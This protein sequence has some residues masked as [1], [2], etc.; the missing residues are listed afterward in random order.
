MALVRVNVPFSGGKNTVVYLPTQNGTLTYNGTNQTP[1]WLNYNPS[2]ISMTGETSATNAGTH[3]VQCTPKG[4]CFW[5]DETQDTKESTWTM[6]KAAGVLSLSVNSTEVK[7]GATGN[8]ILTTA[9]DGAI[10][11]T[12]N[13]T[14]VATVNRNGNTIIITGVK[15]GTATIT[16]SQA[17]GTNHLAPQNVTCSVTVSK[18]IVTVPTVINTS[19]TYNS[20]SQSPTVSNEPSSAI[21]NCTGKSA[22]D[23]GNYTL[24]YS[25]TDTNKYVWSDG[26]TTDKSTAWSIAKANGSISLSVTSGTVTYGTPTTFT[27]TGNTSGGNLSVSSADTRYATASLNGNTVTVTCV[28]CRAETTIITVTSAAT[29]NYNAATATYTMTAAK[30]EGRIT[31]S[32]TS[33]DVTC[34]TPATF[35]VI[36]N[37]SGGI[38]SVETVYNPN[39]KTIYVTPSLNGNTVTVNYVK[40]LDYP[41][42]KIIQV[43]SAETE[44]Y[45]ATYAHYQFYTKKANG[46]VI[47]SATSGTVAY[48]TPSNFE[49][50]ENKSGGK[51][52]AKVANTDTNYAGARIDGNTLIVTCAN[53]RAATSVI[54]V[55]SESTEDYYSASTTFTMTAA[56]GEAFLTLSE[57]SN[58]VYEGK[59]LTI[60]PTTSPVTI[61][62]LVVTSAD[63]NVAVVTASADG[64]VI[65]T[66]VTK[67]T[68]TISISTKEIQ[69]YLPSEIQTFTVTV[70]STISSTLNDNS[71]KIIS[72]VSQKGTGDVYWDIG[73]AKEITLNG[74]IGDE[75]TLTDEKLCVFI[76]HF[77]YPMNGTDENNIIWGGFKSAL[78]GG[79]DVALVDS[80]YS[81][82]ERGDY[83]ESGTICFNMNHFYSKHYDGSYGGWKGC[84]F[85]YDIL[86]ATLTA[87]SEYGK[88]KTTANVGYDATEKTLTSPKKD[89]LLAAIPSDFRNVL[90]L[91]TRWVDAVGDKSDKEEN[92]KATVDA[93]TI[94]SDWEIW[95]DSYVGLS[96]ANSY[97]RNHQ[98][99][100]AYYAAGNSKK[101]YKHND[102]T[103]NAE[104]WTCSLICDAA[105][106]Y[107]NFI[108]IAGDYSF[109]EG[110]EPEMP[111]ALAP[112]FKT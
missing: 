67:G 18:T 50:I 83:P 59:T 102:I 104:Y 79:V 95:G 35:K 85:R 94:L 22:T 24:K 13:N 15:V 108:F 42:Y 17:E 96:I 93:V 12:S 55:T 14:D 97:E 44:N 70:E 48:G 111:K 72:E 109:R 53:Y 90:R 100:M 31:L 20:N 46:S 32:E 49:I 73:D 75:L 3:K 82:M 60:R 27:I 77:N 84:D 91:W 78:T 61:K 7:V 87:P 45:K 101:H 112:A 57:T 80:Q 62:S 8:V 71:W 99:Q 64:R 30:A 43:N 11:V 69:N 9:G 36:E 68:T 37:I 86:G 29:A 54:T 56:K 106:I 16:V 40:M 58:T 5:E 47:L 33:G 74:K 23:V 28:K 107:P 88:H 25:L 81:K 10:T 66:G 2:Q 39:D 89:T 76:L 110:V 41:S 6:N 105:Y 21:A 98:T 52:S 92:I 65:I 103:T 4:R 19:K 26:T 63:T 34:E 51:L 38:L 1:S